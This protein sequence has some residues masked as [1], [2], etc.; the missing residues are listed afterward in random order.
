MILREFHAKPS[1]VQPRLSK[2]THNCE[3]IFYWLNMNGDAIEFVVRC[4]NYQRVKAE[5]KYP[6]GLLQLI[7]I[8]KW[9][10]KVGFAKGIILND[11]W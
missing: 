9:K 3:E 1:L 4:F 2:D 5:F 8:P 6:G 7:V 10:W 11:S